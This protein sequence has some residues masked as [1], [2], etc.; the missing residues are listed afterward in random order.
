LQKDTKADSKSKTDKA[1]DKIKKN[2]E[3]L[4]QE[5]SSQQKEK[6]K[7]D[8]FLEGHKDDII[9]NFFNSEHNMAFVQYCCLPRLRLS[10]S[11]AIFTVKF[12]NAMMTLKRYPYLDQL[13]FKFNIVKTLFPSVQCCSEMEAKNLGIFFREILSMTENIHDNSKLYSVE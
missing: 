3:I 12:L 8:A 1:T 11:D 5:H 2:I 6:E 7:I 4:K 10:P 9:R 13:E